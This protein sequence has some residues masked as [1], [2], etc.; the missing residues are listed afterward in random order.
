M[1]RVAA[2]TLATVLGLTMVAFFY[3][4]PCCSAGLELWRKVQAGENTGDEFP[5]MLKK[6]Q[7]TQHLNQQLP[8]ECGVC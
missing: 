2:A 3:P 4:D 6:V 1:K 8:L 5:K 7:V